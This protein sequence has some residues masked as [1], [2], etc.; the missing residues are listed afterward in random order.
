M[1]QPPVASEMANSLQH[2]SHGSPATSTAANPLK[3]PC[4]GS[5]LTSCLCG[6]SGPLPSAEE[7]AEALRAVA[8]ETYED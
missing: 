6:V 7:L 5:S 4:S 3:A 8:P 2:A 1:Q